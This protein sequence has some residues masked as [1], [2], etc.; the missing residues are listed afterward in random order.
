MSKKVTDFLWIR[1]IIL[2]AKQSRE[3]DHDPRDGAI[4]RVPD[5]SFDHWRD[6]YGWIIGA[7]VILTVI[8]LIIVQYRSMRPT[9]A[10]TLVALATGFG[11]GGLLFVPSVPR[12]LTTLRHFVIPRAPTATSGPFQVTAVNAALLASAAND[13]TIVVQIWYPVAANLPATDLLSGSATPVACSKVMDDRRLSDTRSQFPILLYAPWN[14]GVKDDNASTA[15]ELASHGYVVMAIDDIDRDPRSPTATDD[16]QPLTYD[17]PSAEAF[18]TTLRIGDRKVRRQ[19]EKALTALDRL[20]ACANADWRARIQFDRIGFFGFSFGGATAAEAG[21]FDPRVVAVANLDGDLFGSA[22]FG[23][24]DK[25][26][27]II[28]S[29]NAVFPAPRQ[30]QSPNPNTRFEAA[31]DARDLREEVRLANRPGGYGFRVLESFHENFSDQ[32]FKHRFSMAWLLTNPCRVKS[33]R[34]AY[35][36]AFFDTY[37]RNMPSPLLTQSPSPFREVEVLKANEY[38][39]KEAAKSTSQS[40]AESN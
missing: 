28:L 15:A 13:P 34:D 38:W 26:Y 7:L 6:R 25:P 19:A 9:R 40:S 20:K 16:W 36:L 18:K 31:L 27:L 10:F 29:G 12:I 39:L 24:L 5:M 3:V 8:V 21:T 1:F 22:A 35:L 17:F 2:I 11:I 32:I 23:A 37:V 4:A 14:G 30:L 33:I